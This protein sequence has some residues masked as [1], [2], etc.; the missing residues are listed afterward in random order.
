M[1]NRVIKFTAIVV[2]WF[3]KL[4]GNTYHSVRIT[5]HRDDAIIACPFTYGYGYAYEQTTLQAMFD[6]GW[7][8][9]YK[10]TVLADIHASDKMKQVRYTKNTTSL[11]QREKNYPILFTVSTGLKR[12][13]I[14]NGTT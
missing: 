2:K 5:R 4:N 7:L 3:D 10:R 11:F 6:A 1:N 14:A 9:Y 8:K 12:E 13:C